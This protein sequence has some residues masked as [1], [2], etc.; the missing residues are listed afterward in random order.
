M[1]AV[2]FVPLNICVFFIKQTE[3]ALRKVAIMRQSR[4]AGQ[5]GKPQ[6]YFNIY[7]FTSTPGGNNIPPATIPQLLLGKLVYHYYN[8]LC[9]PSI[10]T[11]CWPCQFR[12]K[13]SDRG[14]CQTSPLLEERK[15][16]AEAVISSHNGGHLVFTLA[17]SYNPCEQLSPHWLA[18][19]GHFN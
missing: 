18:F 10:S 17:G 1:A 7:P 12:R 6:R 19:N 4:S 16:R 2:F 15:E 11:D 14:M 13:H 9:F 5:F 3:I 8:N